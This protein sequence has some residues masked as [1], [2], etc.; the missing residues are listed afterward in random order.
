MTSATS[1]SCW[2]DVTEQSVWATDDPRD[3]VVQ[4]L[5]KARTIATVEQADM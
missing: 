2:A 1:V 5:R 3:P 4:F